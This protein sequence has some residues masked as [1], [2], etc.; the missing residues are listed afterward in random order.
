MVKC[1]DQNTP[2]DCESVKK[3]K[4][5]DNKCT[6]RKV[7]FKVNNKQPNNKKAAGLSKRKNKKRRLRRKRTHKR[8]KRR[9]N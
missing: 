5:N 1:K 6:T 7:K 3:C 8:S 9:R 2:D 4:W